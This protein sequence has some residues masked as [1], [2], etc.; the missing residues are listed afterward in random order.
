MYQ[1]QSET[2]DFSRYTDSLPAYWWKFDLSETF[3]KRKAREPKCRKISMPPPPS[4]LVS[5]RWGV[6][7]QK[8]RFGADAFPYE[9]LVNLWGEKLVTFIF[10]GCNSKLKALWPWQFRWIMFFFGLLFLF[11]RVMFQVLFKVYQEGV[12]VFNAK[13]NFKKYEEGCSADIIAA[14][15][16]WE[17]VARLQDRITSEKINMQSQK[18]SLC[19]WFSRGGDFWR[20]QPLNWAGRTMWRR[21][22]RD[23]QAVLHS[24]MT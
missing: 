4:W 22:G 15:P 19:R 20:F 10:E 16:H 7:F 3:R 21:G 18:C 11:A 9:K 1:R 5:S 6:T 14:A 2:S 13:E 17:L 12:R 24:C 8:W 23:T